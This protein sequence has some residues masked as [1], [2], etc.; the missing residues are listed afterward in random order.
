MRN[1]NRESLRGYCTLVG[2]RPPLET[3]LLSGDRGFLRVNSCHRNWGPKLSPFGRLRVG[4]HDGPNA[5]MAAQC[6]R[7]RAADTLHKLLATGKGLTRQTKAVNYNG[8]GFKCQGRQTL[9]SL[10]ATVC[11]FPACEHAFRRTISRPRTSC[12]GASLGLL[13]GPPECHCSQYKSPLTRLFLSEEMS[14]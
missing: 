6:H 8:T 14:P 10:C 11:C 2:V 7:A 1:D 4:L 9:Q 5:C 12:H 3:A 13:V